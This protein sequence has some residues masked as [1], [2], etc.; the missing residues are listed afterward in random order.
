MAA[1]IHPGKAPCRTKL[2]RF[3]RN[4]RFETLGYSQVQLAALAGISSTGI[5]YIES[6]GKHPT[7]AIVRRLAAA[8]QCSPRKLWSMTSPR[9]PM[10]TK[11][12]LGRLLWRHCVRRGWTVG[13]VAD[14]LEM[15]V[16]R[17][18]AF[19]VHRGP[20]TSVKTAHRLSAAL[21]IKPEVLL[22]FTGVGR[23]AAQ[24]P[25]GALIDE[26]RKVR[27]LETTE[28]A[29]RLGVTKQYIHQLILGRLS[30][31]E[32]NRL[33]RRLARILGLPY[34]K[35]ESLRPVRGIK[36]VAT[37]DPF[38]MFLVERRAALGLPRGY[39]V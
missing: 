5:S 31:A 8:L 18:R 11:H 34:A 27:G 26:A 15:S 10:E 35:L 39:V 22:P 25:F 32:S 36:S 7:D 37:S 13:D 3:V 16:R 21:A 30:L 23:L 38:G 6:R 19:L 28:L 1:K 20:R 2:G 33:L 9:S 4:R 17:A 24:S 14:R 29:R 12:E